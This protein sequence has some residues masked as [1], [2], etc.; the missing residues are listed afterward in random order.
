MKPM[1]ERVMKALSELLEYAEY[2]GGGCEDESYRECLANGDDVSEHIRQAIQI[3]RDY[4][5]G[6]EVGARF[7]LGS[8]YATPAA[9]EALEEAERQTKDWK[10][11]PAETPAELFTRHECGDWGDLSQ[12]DKDENELSIKQGFRILSAYTLKATGQKLWVITEADRSKTTILR[13]DEY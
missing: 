2:D 3:L 11:S 1:N 10:N 5:E 6:R 12:E 4:I 7:S 9:L 8:L 13:P